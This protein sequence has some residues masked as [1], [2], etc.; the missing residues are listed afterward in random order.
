MEF[1]LNLEK[2]MQ[3]T[4]GDLQPILDARIPMYTSYTVS[5]AFGLLLFFLIEKSQFL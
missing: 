3:V 5:K 4:G 1:E 2:F